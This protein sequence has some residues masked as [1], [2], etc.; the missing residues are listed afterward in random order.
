MMLSHLLYSTHAQPLSIEASKTERLSRSISH[1]PSLS[2][3]A[4]GS[5]LL[6][7]RTHTALKAQAQRHGVRINKLEQTGGKQA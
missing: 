3:K 7:L 2:S 4:S 1:L 5:L 6:P